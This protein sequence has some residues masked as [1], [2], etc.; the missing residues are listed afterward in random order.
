MTRIVGIPRNRSMYTIARARI[1]K[2]TGPGRLRMIARPSPST[3]TI[4]S[5]ITNATTFLPN[6]RR[7]SGKLS[8]NTSPLK[9][10]S[11]NASHPGAL[12]IS[13]PS[14]VSTTTVLA[15]AM[16]TPRAPCWRCQPLRMRERRSPL[17]PRPALW[18]TGGR[19][20]RI[21]SGPLLPQA[22][23]PVSPGS[24]R[25]IPIDQNRGDPSV[26]SPEA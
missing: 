15:S 17:D 8:R 10:A 11:R 22:V 13:A 26:F 1:G 25:S 12:T 24:T 3:S 7:M 16:S 14:T 18:I 23:Q 19:R 9:N 5:A 21:S 20:G 4:V 2:K 6:F